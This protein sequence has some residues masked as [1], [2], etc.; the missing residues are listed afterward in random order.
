MVRIFGLLK[1]AVV[2]LIADSTM[3]NFRVLARGMSTLG[4]NFKQHQV[5]PDVVD[6]EPVNVI[7]V[8]IRF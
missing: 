1:Y 7:D 5:V 8:S 3:L 2:L 4:K 6:T